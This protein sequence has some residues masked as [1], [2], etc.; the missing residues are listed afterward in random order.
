M[1]TF[2]FHRENNNFDD[3]LNDKVIKPAI[4]ERYRFDEHLI[5]RVDDRPEVLAYLTLIFSEELM[6]MKDLVPDRT[7]KPYIDYAPKKK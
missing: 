2:V 5:I 4:R 1:K 3:V 7:P 6:S